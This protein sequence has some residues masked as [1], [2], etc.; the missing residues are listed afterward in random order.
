MIE[1]GAPGL[2]GLCNDALWA[3]HLMRY[4]MSN[5]QQE[6][7]MWLKSPHINYQR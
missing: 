5:L 4:M 7:I 1:A 3:L 2:C 6:V